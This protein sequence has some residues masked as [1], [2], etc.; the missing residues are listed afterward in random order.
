MLNIGSAYYWVAA[1][2]ISI[3]L[4]WR[5]AKKEDASLVFV[6]GL[7][8]VYPLCLLLVTFFD[9]VSKWILHSY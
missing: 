1:V 5:G 8:A 3:F 6:G 2:V 9:A 4:M 7:I